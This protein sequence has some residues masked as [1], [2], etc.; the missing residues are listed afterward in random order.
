MWLRDPNNWPHQPMI[1]SNEESEIERKRVK[2]I[3]AVT[4][5]F[6]TIYDKL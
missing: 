6:E 1:E 3:F 4:V 5:S 2:E